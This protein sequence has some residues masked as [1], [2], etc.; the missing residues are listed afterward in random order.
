MKTNKFFSVNPK[1][2]LGEITSK[3]IEISKDPARW[4]KLSS[5]I[6]TFDQESILAIEEENTAVSVLLNGLL[7]D[8]MPF[9]AVSDKDVLGVGVICIRSYQEAIRLFGEE[10]PSLKSLTEYLLEKK[11]NSREA[12]RNYLMSQTSEEENEREINSL[13]LM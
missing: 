9:T 1:N 2:I 7:L 8:Y 13:P 3:L 6:S 10:S 5:W 4:D 11:I 12:Y